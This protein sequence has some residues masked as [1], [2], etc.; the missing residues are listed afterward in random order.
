MH[1]EVDQ[2]GKIEQTRWDTIL[3]FSDGLSSSILIPAKVKREAIVRLRSTGRRGKRLYLPLFVAGL[4]LLL[5]DHLGK[6]NL[7]TIDREYWGSERDIKAQLLR[8]I[9]RV[10]PN[11]EAEWIEFRLIGKGS[12]AHSKARAVYEG[13]KEP[14]RRIQLEE[15]LEVLG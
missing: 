9:W 13:K 2:S 3:A 7:I 15:L 5:S 12:P 14:D 11:F 1:V 6:L 10:C 4:Y 8:L